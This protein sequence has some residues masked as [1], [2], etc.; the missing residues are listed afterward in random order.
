MASSRRAATTPLPCSIAWH[1][2]PATAPYRRRPATGVEQY[3]VER[4]AS[5]E[6][7]PRLRGI[8]RDYDRR[9]MWLE[10]LLKEPADRTRI[11]DREHALTLEPIDHFHCSSG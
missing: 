4:A 5:A 10:Q 9:G 7:R 11:V 2:A 6:L 1:E 3:E 8:G